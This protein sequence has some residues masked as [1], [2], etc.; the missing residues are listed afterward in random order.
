[1]LHAGCGVG[2]HLGA[3]LEFSDGVVCS[4]ASV[5]DVAWRENS[6]EPTSSLTVTLADRCR[7]HRRPRR[8]ATIGKL[9]Q[10]SAL[11][12]RGGGLFVMSS[13]SE[14]GS[15]DIRRMAVWRSGGVVGRTDWAHS[16]GP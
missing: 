2:G 7:R 15:V 3:E 6:C 10:L 14:T 4:A 9:R 1:M 12:V 13:V 8:S 16:M 11:C 5:S